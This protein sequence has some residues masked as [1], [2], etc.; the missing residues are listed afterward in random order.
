MTG[1]PDAA[2]RLFSYP[3][4]QQLLAQPK[5]AAVFTDPAV[6]KAA[7]EGNYFALLSSPQL[8]AAA[9]DP[10]VQKSFTGFDWQKALDYALQESAPSSVPS[11]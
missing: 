8:S 7:A 1:S 5:I 2:A 10:E 11:P 9:S 6:A 4:L 3:P